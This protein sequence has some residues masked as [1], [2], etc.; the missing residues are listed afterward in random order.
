M[1][2]LIPMA[3]EGKRFN[4]VGYRLPKPLIPVS[5]KPMILNVLKDLPKD[6]E[7]ILVVQEKHAADFDIDEL[8]HGED[9]VNL[10]KI[11]GRTEGQASTCLL[12]ENHLDPEEELLIAASDNGMLVDWTRFNSEKRHSDCL[13]LT[14][15]GQDR[16]SENPNSWGWCKIDTEN[17]I[18]DISVKVPISGTPE[19]DHAIVGAFYFKKARYFI[20]SAKRMIKEDYR[21]NNEFYVDSVPLFMPSGTISRVFEIDHYAG[22]GT[23]ADLYEYQEKEY[24]YRIGYGILE[25]VWKQYFRR[26]LE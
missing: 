20:E 14:F 11:S 10:I 13:V 16:L 8:F 21:T 15:R 25:E 12:A 23:P 24:M 22:W 7:C 17:N 5:G 19:R 1:K 3:G 26:H 9:N 2:I 4:E 6:I 18:K